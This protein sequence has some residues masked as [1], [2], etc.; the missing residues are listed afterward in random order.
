MNLIREYN[1][2]LPKKKY[3]SKAGQNYNLK[4][5]QR[6][7]LI[8]EI[9]F[10][11]RYYKD[12]RQNEKKYLLYVGASPGI[13]INY[14]KIMFPDLHYILYDKVESKVE[15]SN[16]VVFH[17]KYFDDEEAKK[18]VNMNLFF[19]CD[20]RSLNVGTHLTKMRK[21]NNILKKEEEIVDN[22]IFDDMDAQ[23]RWCKIMKPIQSHLKFRLLYNNPTT[24]YFDGKLFFQPWTGNISAE[25]RLVPDLNSTKNWDNKLMEE[26]VF[27]YNTEIRKKK[28][29][30]ITSEIL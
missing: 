22:L 5:G 16:N 29:N 9:D 21:N 25:L 23:Y 4:W 2:N 1:E 10:L 17:K 3:Y 20:I 8:T 28:I 27:Y 13:H 14:L 11:N 24:K 15:K 7:L 12:Y 26:I 19:I 6:K 30:G 18:Y